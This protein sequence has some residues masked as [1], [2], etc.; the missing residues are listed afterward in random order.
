LLLN[1]G[2]IF[3]S[4]VATFTPPTGFTAL[5]TAAVFFPRFYG[6]EGIPDV[7]WYAQ[8]VFD[9]NSTGALA[10]W[11]FDQ[12]LPPGI[13]LKVPPAL[14]NT[15]PDQA[16]SYTTVAGD[17][18]MYIGAALSLDQQFATGTG[19][20]ANWPTFRSQVVDS[21]GSMSIPARVGS[22]RLTA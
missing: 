15:N 8:T 19:P 21:G 17:T 18:L 5:L 2:G 13:V 7:E 22:L 11:T 16:I 12:P 4:P 1:P 14:N 3:T 9:F 20:V 10:G 6:R